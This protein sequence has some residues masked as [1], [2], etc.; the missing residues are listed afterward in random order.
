MKTAR[1]TYPT[2]FCLAPTESLRTPRAIIGRHT[3]HWDEY[4]SPRL[5]NEELIHFDMDVEAIWMH[6]TPKEYITPQGEVTTSAHNF[7]VNVVGHHQKKVVAYLISGDRITALCE[8]A[9]VAQRPDSTSTRTVEE[10]LAAVDSVIASVYRYCKV[11]SKNENRKA[12]DLLYQ[13][14]GYA[15]EQ[16][17]LECVNSF[18]ETLDPKQISGGA[19][20]SALQVSKSVREFTPQRE[21]F[22]SR[23]FSHFKDIYGP[24]KAKRMLLRLK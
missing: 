15:I 2:D 6:G 23:S 7:M 9:R 19:T 4:L 16:D 13:Y 21:D 24:E 8:E 18:L 3:S 5:D 20:L 10:N 17:N 12:I 11:N 1:T 22:W 14:L